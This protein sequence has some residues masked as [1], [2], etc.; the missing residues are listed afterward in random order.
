MPETTEIRS[1]LVWAAC[2]PAARSAQAIGLSS[3]PSTAGSDGAQHELERV[4]LGVAQP[5]QQVGIY[6]DACAAG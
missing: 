6:K 2:K 5:G 4:A 1:P 3:A